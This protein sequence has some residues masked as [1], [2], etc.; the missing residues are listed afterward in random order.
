[1]PFGDYQK[2][3]D[4]WVQQFNPS[5]WPIHEQFAHLVEEVGEL[6]RE[7]NHLY[8]IKKKKACEKGGSLEEQLAEIAFVLCC[9]ANS[10]NIDLHKEW[11]KMM[12]ERHYKRDN[13]RFKR[14]NEL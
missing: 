10:K 2:Q 7:V 9:M 6:G 11:E 5:Y 8:G 4:D 1:M 14:K 3:V 12:K 13:Q